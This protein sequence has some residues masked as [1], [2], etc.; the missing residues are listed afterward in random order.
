MK[1]FLLSVLSN[2]QSIKSLAKYMFATALFLLFSTNANA[3]INPGS[4]SGLRVWFR[5]DSSAV[6]TGNKVISLND[7]SGSNSHATQADTS[8]QPSLVTNILNG[9]P[10]VRFDGVN[11]FLAT[12]NFLVTAS[13]PNTIFIVWN[14]AATGSAAQTALSGLNNTESNGIFHALATSRL[15]IFSGSSVYYTKTA[16]FN[17]IITTAVYNGANSAMREN[18]V[19]RTLTPNSNSGTQGFKM[20]HIGAN[21]GTASFLKGDVAEVIVYN[22]ILTTQQR[23]DVEQYLRLRYA[24]QINLGPDLVFSNK[25][26]H[27]LSIGN[28]FTN[29]QWRNSTGVLGTSS[30]LPINK[31]GKYWVTAN[32]SFGYQSVDTINV[33]FDVIQGLNTLNTTIC[34]GASAKLYPK[35][36]PTA[37]GTFTYLW[38][39][40]STT[41]TL[42]VSG[43]GSYILRVTDAFGCTSILDT[44]KVKLDTFKLRNLLP[45]SVS[46]CSGTTLEPLIPLVDIGFIQWSNNQNT[47]LTVVNDTGKLSVIITN[48]RGCEA[49]DT[50]QVFISGIAPFSKFFTDTV[51]LGNTTPFFNQSLPGTTTDLIVKQLWKF[52]NGDSSLSINPTY[53]YPIAG[54]YQVT[55]TNITQAGCVSS[56]VKSV[57]VR[58]ALAASFNAAEACINDQILIFENSAATLP[59]VINQWK[60]NF[61][62]GDTSTVRVPNYTYSI[63]GGYSVQLTVKSVFGCSK[64]FTKVLNV[65][66]VTPPPAITSLS[67][68]ND[69]FIT[70]DSLV[71]FSWSNAVG[72]VSFRLQVSATNQF[73]TQSK[74][75]LVIVNSISLNLSTG[76]HYWRVIAFSACDSSSTSNSRV[77]NVF[78]PAL[79]GNLVFWGNGGNVVQNGN[80]VSEI[81]DLSGKNHHAIQLDGTKQPSLVS[82]VLNGKPI[83]RFDGTDDFLATP[84]FSATSDTPNTIFIVWNIA[85]TGSA[86]QAVLS[87]LSNTESNGIFHSLAN[88]R[89]NMFSGATVYYA[90]TA[91][92]SHIITSAVYRGISSLM[93]ENGVGKTLIPSSNAGGQGFKMLHIGANYGTSSFLRGDVA[94]IIAYNSA[95]TAQQRTNV[96]QYLRFKYAPQIDLGP[97]LVFSNKFCHTLSVGNSFTNIQWRNSTGVLG[98]SN[99]LTINKSGKYWVTANDIFGYQ[100]TDTILLEFPSVTLN[101]ADTTFCLGDSVKFYPVFSQGAQGTYS[102][103]WSNGVL[104]DTLN[105]SNGGK[106]ILSVTDA[107]NCSVVL[108]TLRVKLDI[109]QLRNLLPNDTTLCIGSDLGLYASPSEVK[110]LLWSNGDTTFLTQIQS[111]GSI[112]VFVQNNTGCKARDTIY[113][114]SISGT[115]PTTSFTSDTVCLGNNT[116]F[117]NQSSVA[118]PSDTIVSQLWQFGNG[119]TSTNF[120]VSYKYSAAGNY[121]VTLTNVTSDGCVKSVRLKSVVHPGLTVNFEIPTAC[122]LKP[123]LVKE[124]STALLPDA[125]NSWMWSFGNGDIDNNKIP[126]YSYPNAGIYN[127]KLIASSIL[128][129]VDSI[130]KTLTVVS[131][132]PT[133]G[134]ADLLLPVQN[135]VS[136]DSVVS[137][138]WNPATDASFYRLQISSQANFQSLLIDTLTQNNS[139]ILGL[140]TAIY[141]WRIVSFSP[142]GGTSF[143]LYR[144]ITILNLKNL[145]NI[146]YWGDG[147]SV[148]KN[149]N[150]VSEIKD[151]S[152]KNHHAIQS[153]VTKQPISV[154]NVLNGKPVIRFDGTD[155]FMVTNNFTNPVPQPNTVFLVWNIRQLGNAAQTVFSGINNTNTNTIFHNRANQQLNFFAGTSGNYGK[156]APFNHLIS[157]TV[158]NGAASLVREN[159]V[160]KVLST[161]ILGSQGLSVIH[162]GCAYGTGSFLF[163]DLAEAIVYN[164]NLTVT[165]RTDVEQYLRF[166][167]APQINLGLDIKIAY[168]VCD[169]TLDA[170]PN[171]TNIKWNTGATTRT[172]K[173]KKA[174][175]YWVTANDIFGYV[176]SD[177]INVS[178]PFKGILPTKDTIIC[179]GKSVELAAQIVG[180]PYSFLWSTGDT[181]NSI[182]TSISGTYF[183]QVSDTIGCT[184]TSDTITVSIDSLQFFSVLDDDTVAC[185]NSPLGLYP[186]IYP[187]QTFQ[188]STGGNKD[189]I[190]ISGTGKFYVTV[191]DVN[192]C[193][194]IDSI[195]ISRLKG[196]A[197]IVNFGYTNICLGDTTSFTDS[198][199]ITAPEIIAI[200]Q[201]TFGSNIPADT[202]VNP[203][204]VFPNTS[205]YPVRLYVETDSGC[206][207]SKAINLQIGAR[208]L[209]FISY[210]VS[211]ANTPVILSD[212][213][214]IPLGDTIK[215]W[216]W[217][218]NSGNVFLTKNVTY[219]FPS[220][221]EFPVKL[222]VTSAKGCVD[223]TSV[224]VEVFPPINPNF[225]YSNQCV[226]QTTL[227]SDVTP[228]LS[229][230]KRIWR[231]SDQVALINDS[232]SFKKVFASADTFQVTL[233]VTNAIGCVDTV[234]KSV[235]IYPNP[236]AQITD[237]VACKGASVKLTENTQSDDSIVRYDWI[238]GGTLSKQ[239]N[240]TFVVNDT[241][242]IAMQLKV[243][244]LQGCIDSVQRNFRV[245]GLPKASFAYSPLFGESPLEVTFTNTSNNAVSYSWNFG[246]GTGTSTVK[247][248]VY[249]YTFND[250]FAIKLTAANQLGCADS[251]IRNIVVI[252]TDADIQLL[253]INTQNKQLLNGALSTE[254][255]ARFANVGTQPIINAQFLARLDDGTTI[256]DDW[257]G[258]LLPGDVYVHTF[259]SSF[260][261][262]KSSVVQ[263]VCV[264]AVNIN[265]GAEKRLENNKNCRSLTDQS[266]VTNLYPNPAS[267]EIFLDLILPEE[268]D[269]SFEV[270]NEMGQKMIAKFDFKGV[271]GINTVPFDVRAFRPGIYFL[272]IKYKDSTEVQKFQVIR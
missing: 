76:V 217:N 261:L 21:Y 11:D 170:G 238:F 171:F 103:Q 53:Q 107:F 123:I 65:Y 4:I 59:D 101:I 79:L 85:A 60:W 264:D 51:C 70:G 194:V 97:D 113:T 181:T 78:N 125:I 197:P 83:I 94:E 219:N 190:L 266:V 180:S 15:N 229:I 216:N 7:L 162:L 224:K 1:N 24:P 154:A 159:G 112:D 29:I 252:P 9:K 18:G 218:I 84:N 235:V 2:L 100:T 203:F 207:N 251:V 88:S 71:N 105:L 256:L 232:L 255:L 168:G 31:N 27:T 183:V 246:D 161:N 242:L 30:S 249:T 192:G 173:V 45:A 265:N 110:S 231:L 148:I 160:G 77:I 263:Y 124:K 140:N 56:I 116:A 257:E 117:S 22:S 49:Y 14:I 142:C 109:F 99:S 108:D 73:L 262:P 254:V 136:A 169:T 87:G 96:E 200:R 126:N 259:S 115:V 212:A 269:F 16:P 149:G 93:R 209:P 80:S 92:F 95:L 233:E 221:G 205:A 121:Q 6:V 206:F 66:S 137:F 222:I 258:I 90:K 3:Q 172:I 182:F 17:H 157:S 189:T 119:D 86:A 166:K 268:T 191:T 34:L 184:L 151:L 62:N 201:W 220:I 52:G 145:G 239:R 46:V 111:G 98:A 48:I 132:S 237:T 25:F 146:I 114:I 138:N 38:S 202:V 10:I 58:A 156:L 225:T 43:E 91:P 267:G 147:S 32:D 8:K 176:T 245:L 106:Y 198:T 187:Y 163:G 243:T 69:A 141:Y 188:W 20:L 208:P 178:T 13:Q 270:S 120:N 150:S 227:I 134:S 175:T 89:L 128:G 226:G 102:Y 152:G 63:A 144:T 167:Y 40:G 50:T 139:I 196:V 54:T 36:S 271:R 214:T 234:T 213:S 199:K 211:C 47:Y 81:K 135:F 253:T 248:P 177:T 28:G 228:S 82:N 33:M 5:A 174:G 195:N 179:E 247:N 68:P 37:S 244:S 67:Q 215:F 118:F 61:G 260:Y 19:G 129:C 230:I 186:Y 131:S 158:F 64:S 130:V 185:T 165:Q 72:A 26:C 223:S 57:L 272:R 193:A 55:L 75:T 133:P 12:S 35:F 42:L 241:G 39:N 236:D 104:A 41:D 164:S 250:T 153:D 240:P 23:N 122:V 127:V 210:N 44:I 143:S 74:D 204:V 155:D